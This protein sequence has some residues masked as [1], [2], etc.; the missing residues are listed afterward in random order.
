MAACDIDGDGKV[1]LLA[2]NFWLKHR[3]GKRFEAIRIG[4]IGG[5]IAAGKLKPGKYPQVV[6][7]PGDGTGPLRW[8]EC[9]GN[10]EVGTDWIGHDLL[11]RDMI[12]GHSLQIADIDGDGHLDIF[13]G[14]DG[15][16]DRKR[17]TTGQS[18]RHG[19]DFL[20]GWARPFS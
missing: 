2:G 10:P 6:I 12:H 17:H 13:R 1:D 4:A 14:R 3:G 18:R 19:L 11:E 16:V 9:I 8:Y 5:R 7:A 20:W 15:Q